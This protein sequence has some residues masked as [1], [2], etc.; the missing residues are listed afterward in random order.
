MKTTISSGNTTDDLKIYLSK[1]HLFA[2][3]SNSKVTENHNHPRSWKL[4]GSGDG[5]STWTLLDTQTGFTFG[6]LT[7]ATLSHEFEVTS[8]ESHNEFK[9]EVLEV[10]GDHASGQ[11]DASNYFSNDRRI[12]LGQDVLRRI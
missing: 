2:R 9:L 10:M 6:G 8:T 4:Y 1:Y 7:G 5:G 12:Q 11:T 3:T